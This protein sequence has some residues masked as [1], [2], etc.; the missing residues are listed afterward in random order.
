MNHDKDNAETLN[1]AVEN[2]DGGLQLLLNINDA[3][4]R[5]RSFRKIK[6]VW[7]IF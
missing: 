2:F 3:T 4:I 6:L 1:V 5:L 7:V